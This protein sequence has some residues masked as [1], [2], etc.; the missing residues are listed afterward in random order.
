MAAINHS[1]ILK[2]SKFPWGSQ[3]AK[4]RRIPSRLEEIAVQ[5]AVEAGALVRTEASVCVAL[6]LEVPESQ[7]FMTQNHAIL[8]SFSISN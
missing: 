6:V 3:T 4:W 7:L 8:L 5:R 2:G 1:F